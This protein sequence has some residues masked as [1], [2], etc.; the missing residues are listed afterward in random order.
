LINELV[1]IPHTIN[2]TEF[3]QCFNYEIIF[4]ESTQIPAVG[5]NKK[6]LRFRVRVF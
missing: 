5:E 3:Q 4:L 6:W 2:A 1:Q